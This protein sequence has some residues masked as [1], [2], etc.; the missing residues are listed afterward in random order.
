MDEQKPVKPEILTKGLAPADVVS[1]MRILW[2]GSI[3]NPAV[4]KD[5]LRNDLHNAWSGPSALAIIAAIVAA[6]VIAIW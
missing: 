3:L 2:L 5:Q 4:M 6:G 1:D